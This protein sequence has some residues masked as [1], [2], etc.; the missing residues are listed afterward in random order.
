MN[1]QYLAILKAY[2]DPACWE[3]PEEFSYQEQQQK[4][5]SAKGLLQNVLRRK[6]NFETGSQIQ[7]ASYHSCIHLDVELLKSSE[8]QSQLR[9][10]NF[11]NMISFVNENSIKESIKIDII[12]HLQNIGYVYIPEA[13]LEEQYTGKNPG[14]SGI[15]T[16][17]VRYFEWV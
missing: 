8:K 15:E 4:F 7:D 9:F 1:D 6:L 16:W 10:S 11:G 12:Q 14:V 17:W 3:Y 2:D 5:F 13:V